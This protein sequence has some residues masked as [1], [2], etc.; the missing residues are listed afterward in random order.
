[1]RTSAGG[2]SWGARSSRGVSV[3]KGAAAAERTTGSLHLTTTIQALLESTCER[4]VVGGE[5]VRASEREWE[6]EAEV[7]TVWGLERR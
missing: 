1:V 3:R 4:W 2:G 5:E 7:S 6:G